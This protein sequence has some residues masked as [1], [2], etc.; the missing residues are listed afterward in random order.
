[1]F[2]ITNFH[3]LAVK[4][5][6]AS[7]AFCVSIIGILS[8]CTPVY[9]TVLTFSNPALNLTFSLLPI[10]S[11]HPHASASHSTFDFW[12]YI[13]IWLTLTLTLSV[14]PIASFVDLGQPPP[15]LPFDILVLGSSVKC[16]GWLK[17]AD[18]KMQHRQ[19]CRTLNYLRSGKRLRRLNAIE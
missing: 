4:S 18:M 11:S 8:L 10:T 13:D 17:M 16:L 7:R 1:M 14:Q 19:N 5:S 6:F 15:S 3:L 2:S 12:R 9:L